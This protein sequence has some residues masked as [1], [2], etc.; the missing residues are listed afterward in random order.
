SVH[1]HHNVAPRRALDGLPS[2]ISRC[3]ISFSP[4]CWTCKELSA[5]RRSIMARPLLPSIVIPIP[6]LVSDI[7]E[8]ILKAT[9]H[10]KKRH[11]QMA[12]KGL[13]DVTSLNKCSGCGRVKRA[14]Y[15]CPHCVMRRDSDKL[16]ASRSGSATTSSPRR[17][18][19]EWEKKDQEKRMD[20]RKHKVDE[21]KA[22][23]S[24]IDETDI[25]DRK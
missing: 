6:G 21:I 13:K 20:Q 9:S 25:V 17:E 23:E 8:S 19:T 11:R 4:P 10:M 15:L 12:G 7:W 2:V 3:R 14:H 16:Q 24:K 18:K 1:I 22:E 5:S